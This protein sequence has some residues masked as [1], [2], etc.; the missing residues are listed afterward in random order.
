MT[1]DELCAIREQRII[2]AY[3]A[4]PE[5]IRDDICEA[6]AWAKKT[7]TDHEGSGH[8][9]YVTAG[10]DGMVVCSFAKVSWAGDHSGR[11]MDHAGEAMVMAVCE[12]LNGG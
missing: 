9:F 6:S 4:V 7:L 5:Y 10:K 3:D 12:Y 11:G 1:S 2:A 8:Q